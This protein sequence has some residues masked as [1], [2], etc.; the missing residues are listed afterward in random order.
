MVGCL[1][2]SVRWGTAV[3]KGCVAVRVEKNSVA[4][5][6]MEQAELRHDV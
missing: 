2:E 5:A 3:V 6:R 1:G 4:S